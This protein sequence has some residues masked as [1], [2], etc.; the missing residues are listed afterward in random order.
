MQYDRD[1]DGSLTPLPSRQHRHRRG[2]RARG[3]AAAGRALRLR[4][5]LLPA[6]H[7]RR[8]G[9][10]GHALRRT[11]AT[12][13]Q[14]LR[15]LADHGRAMTFLA[16][17]GVTARRNEGRGYIL[18][19]IIRRA[20]QH[21]GAHRARRRR[22][23]AGCTDV[24]IE[25][26]GDVYPELVRT[27][28]EVA[29]LL[30]AEEE[31]FAPH[32]AT[33]ARALLDE[34]IERRA[35]AARTAI[36][37]E[38]AFRLHDTYGFPFEL[39]AELAGE[40][41]P[42]R[43][44][45]PASRR[46]WSEQRTRARA[47]RP[48]A[49]ASTPSA[50]RPSCARRRAH[51]VRRLRASCDVETTVIAA[52]DLGDGRALLKLRR[53][54][55]YA[56]GGGQVSDRG[57]RSSPRAAAAAVEAVLRFDDD[58]ALVVRLEHGDARGAAT[59]VDARV[60]ARSPA[61]RRWPTTPARTCCTARCATRWATTCARR[62]SAVR[63]DKLRFDFTHGGRST[64]ERAAG[65]RGRG[66][67]RACVENRAVRTFETAQR[68]GA[69]A[70]R[71]DALRRE[72]RRR[73]ARR[74]DRG[75]S[76][77]LCGGTHV[78][79]TAEVG[80]FRILSESSVGQGVR[81]IEAVTAR[82]RARP[83]A[84]ARARAA[85]EAARELRTDARAAARGD[86]VAARAGAR[87]R[88]GRASRRAAARRPTRPRGAGR[89]RRARQRPA[90]CSSRRRP[91]ATL[92]DALLDLT[93][94]LQRPARPVGRRARRAD[95]RRGRAAR[96]QPLRPRRSRPALD[97]VAVIRAIAPHRRRRRRRAPADG[98]RGRQGREPPGRG[99]RGRG[100]RSADGVKALALD[101]GS[102]RTGVAV[103]DASGTL[104]RPLAIVE[105][106]GTPAGLEA[107]CA[108]IDA[109]ATRGR[110]RGPAADAPR[111]ARPAGRRDRG[112]RRAPA[113]EVPA[114]DR[115]GGRAIH[116]VD[117]QTD[118]YD[119]PTAVAPG[120]PDGSGGPAPG[121]P[122]P[123]EREQAERRRPTAAEA[124]PAGGR[125][126]LL[127]L[128]AVVLLGLREADRRLFGG[129]GGDPGAAVEVT[130]PEGSSVDAIG[131][132]LDRAGVVGNGS[133][134]GHQG[135]PQ[136]RRRRV[137]ARHATRCART[138]TTRSSSR[139]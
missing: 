121:L 17:D 79:R 14:A 99:A 34:V 80:P 57:H 137:Q 15:V 73:R 2:R 37:A 20:V 64:P 67:P 113:R 93:D 71:D 119:W 130:I 62:G 136:G 43:R 53:S 31:R 55:F 42:G 87:A 3:R 108:I 100:A 52:E 59:P 115:D 4:D 104:A 126:A 11:A 70:R 82:R 134:L 72:V 29:R 129:G 6:D 127:A 66:Q 77:E 105:R 51:R 32:A 65:G 94:R 61:R 58:Q 21:G 39:T 125:R 41:G 117:R 114:S 56:E 45:R 128:V 28:D 30:A 33:P 69:A 19:R 48:G 18:R 50:W 5:R 75:Y 107:L 91:R 84:R 44:P 89:R 139:P 116:D 76:R 54:P 85:E 8:R 10:D 23:W 88:E 60:D 109:R 102:A 118:A 35:R 78:A 12:E 9:L 22:S 74:R 133:E 1:D 96:G 46:S 123:Q 40:A 26:L 112:L 86:R 135:A 110:R 68:R 36:P 111:R 106:V 98:A 138:R 7:R 81:R 38:D 13:T 103:S 83:A 63:P 47:P 49:A 120:R 95:E 124:P 101:Y 24:V 16:T 27:R 122:G 25:P 131:D 92:G 97:A 90:A 132:I